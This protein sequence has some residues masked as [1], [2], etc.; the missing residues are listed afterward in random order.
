MSTFV[1][2]GRNSRALFSGGQMSSTEWWKS[3]NPRLQRNLKICLFLIPFLMVASLLAIKFYRPGVY[4]RYAMREDGV[5]EYLSAVSYLLASVFFI[6]SWRRSRSLGNRLVSLG[7]FAAGML[8]FVVSGEEIS[9][10]QRIL[11]IATPESISEVNRQGELTLHNLEGL[12]RYQLPG[13]LSIAFLGTFG[14]VALAALPKRARDSLTGTGLSRFVPDWF[15][16]SYFLVLLVVFSAMTYL[17]GPLIDVF[18]EAVRKG[19]GHFVSGDQEPA[20]AVFSLGVM[21][22]AALGYL[23]LRDEPPE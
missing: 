13:Y 6:L 20:E 9:W 18:G 2:R 17:Q 21:L 5:L 19:G 8:F 10:G 1:L 14:W 15:L 12:H 3:P 23:R 16:S 22:F 11:G 7:Y 4:Y